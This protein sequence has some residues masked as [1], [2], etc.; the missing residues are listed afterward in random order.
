VGEN[1]LN[2]DL[3]NLRPTLNANNYFV[4]D[5]YY[6]WGPPDQ[7]VGDGTI[8]DHTDVGHWFNWF[9]GP[10]RDTYLAD[11]YSTSHIT[12]GTGTN[13]IPD[14]GGSNTVV[15]FKSCYPNGQHIGGNP[16]DA[17]WI[18]SP[19]NRNPIY[20]PV[21]QAA[22]DPNVY[23]VSSIKGLYRDLL[24]YF[25]TRQ[26]K[27]FILIATP[28]SSPTDPDIDAASAANTRAITSWLIYHWL[29]AYPHRNVAVFDFFNI[30][31]SNGGDPDTND[32]GAAGGN[33]HRL[34]E[35]KV[36]H[37]RQLDNNFSAYCWGADSH[38]SGAGGQKA[39]GEF[40]QL[41][42]AAYHY[43]QGDGGRPLLM[44]WSG[45][46]PHVPLLLLD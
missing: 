43:W 26:D 9:L 28:P 23:T 6:G 39:S 29:D 35:G 24:Q 8:G 14:P 20:D 32:L 37:L 45:P 7:D 31:T 42:N 19:A 2:P 5:T 41:L 38:P 33:H 36:Q 30:L 34:L 4:V 16:G 1:W 46:I 22:G 25:A 17:P 3:G 21:G 12:P 13:S 40:P 11:L 27:L 10:H 15:M 18:N 44:G